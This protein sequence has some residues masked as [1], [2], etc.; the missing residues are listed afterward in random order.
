MTEIFD[1]R[2]KKICIAD[3]TEG[4][5]IKKYKA[6]VTIIAM[7]VGNHITIDHGGAVTRITRDT[8]TTFKIE[9][10]LHGK[11]KAG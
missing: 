8:P 3:E 9:R 4:V 6:D 10:S 1:L 7:S 5:V 2:G 11:T